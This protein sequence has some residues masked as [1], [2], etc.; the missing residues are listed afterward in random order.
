MPCELKKRSEGGEEIRR[1]HV[2]V[3]RLLS[4]S[5]ELVLNS[6][7]ISLL[8]T[9]LTCVCGLNI[10][11]ISVCN[12]F[13]QLHDGVKKSGIMGFCDPC[14]G[15]PKQLYVMYTYGENRYEVGIST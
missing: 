13:V 9:D 6:F 4:C 8:I 10:V 2:L 14:P 1:L 3:F 11:L 7:L 12:M 15:E 5:F